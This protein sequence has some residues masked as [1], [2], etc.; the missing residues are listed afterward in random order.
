MSVSK[1]VTKD[2]FRIVGNIE[3]SGDI[4]PIQSGI[5]DLG[6]PDQRFKDIY[7]ADHLDGF[8]PRIHFG[9]FDF[10]ATNVI[11]AR[12]AAALA[13]TA[14]QPGTVDFSTD[15]WNLPTT[16]A[17]YGI[18][19]AVIPGDFV[20][21]AS[22]SLEGSATI[23]TSTSNL[24]VSGTGDAIFESDVF[25]ES[26][27]TLTGL[28]VT[29]N[30]NL[31]GDLIHD[32]NLIPATNN[33]SDLGTT[34][35]RY[36]AA[37]VN[38][39]LYIGAETFKDTDVGTIRD[40]QNGAYATAAQGALADSALQPHDDI[41]VNHI[42]L[43]G[44][45]RG[46]STTYI[47]P[48]GFGD[49]TGKVIIL[50]DLQV[51]GV[52]TTVNST[53]VAVSGKVINLAQGSA[54]AFAA[55][56]SG[57]NV[58]GSGATFK[59]MAGTDCWTTNKRVGIN[60][61]GSTDVTLSV[62][63]SYTG[64]TN[65]DIFHAVDLLDNTRV[66]I[67]DTYDLILS[68]TVNDLTILRSDGRVGI[69]T[70]NPTAALHV[71]TTDAIMLP[72]GTTVQRPLTPTQSQRGYIRYNT[73]TNKLEAF[74]KNDVWYNLESVMDSDKDTYITPELTDGNDDDS[75]HFF[76]RGTEQMSL[77]PAGRLGIGTTTPGGKLHLQTSTVTETNPTFIIESPNPSI[78]FIDNTNVGDMNIQWQSSEGDEPGLRFFRTDPTDPDMVIG[79]EG[80]VGINLTE[81]T[82]PL[83]VV[84][85]NTGLLVD[86]QNPA[87][88]HG[89]RV[90]SGNNEFNDGSEVVLDVRSGTTN[91][92]ILNAHAGSHVGIGTASP[93]RT[94]H[95]QSGEDNVTARFTSTDTAVQIELEDLT[96]R[97]WI[98]ARNDFRFGNNIEELMRIDSTGDVG[99]G[100]QDPLYPLHI[101][102]TDTDRARNNVVSIERAFTPVGAGV[103]Q[104]RFEKNV[105][106][107]SRWCN[108]PVNSTENGY[109]IAL[110]ASCYIADTDFK[111]Y[112]E[113]NYGIWARAGAYTNSND[114]TNQNPTGTINKSYA[115]YVDCL[116]SDNVTINNSYG[117]YQSA[118]Y[119]DSADD[120]KNFFASRV[121]IG[122]EDPA[123]KLQV[124]GPGTIA[125]TDLSK[126]YILAGT[127]T[128][129]IGIDPNEIVC[130]GSSLNIGTA[131]GNTNDVHLR[132]N[133]TNN[134]LTVDGA[135]GRVGINTSSPEE[136]LTVD[137][138]I[139]F[140]ATGNYNQFTMKTTAKFGIYEGVL[141]IRN[142]TIPGTG[143]SEH[144]THFATHSSTT[145]ST[146]HDV[147]IDGRVGIGHVAPGA[148]L[149]VR[150]NQNNSTE[151]DWRN[152]D[153]IKV[154]NESTA[155]GSLMSLQL[156]SP[157]SSI[158]LVG[159]RVSEDS[160]NFHIIS[161]S[162]DGDPVSIMKMT[163][164]GLVGIRKSPSYALDVYGVEET[165]I[166]VDTST[167]DN[168]ALVRFAHQGTNHFVIGHEGDTDKFT[169][170]DNIA[171]KHRLTIDSDGRVGINEYNPETM[172][173]IHANTSSQNPTKFITLTNYSPDLEFNSSLISFQFVDDNSNDDPQVQIGAI[174]GANANANGFIPEGAGAFIV[175]TNNPYTANPD[176]E[177][178]TA[179]NDATDLQERF[180]V[181][182]RGYVGIG[183]S[184]PD[185]MLEID[186]GTGTNV[187]MTLRMGSGSGG[188]ND[189]FISF[190]NSQGSE[191]FRTRF[192][193]DSANERYVISTDQGGDTL[194]V[195]RS[196]NVEIQGDSA[197]N[198]TSS[199][200][201]LVKH[202]KNTISMFLG[203]N[204]VTSGYGTNDYSG[205]IRFNGR[206]VGW[207]D[208]SYYPTATNDLNSMGHFRFTKNGSTVNST[209][210]ARVG[211][212]SL[213][214]H[215]DVQVE[216]DIQAPTMKG[217][218]WTSS[219]Y[220]L[221]T[222]IKPAD[223]VVME[224]VGWSNPNTNGRSEY[225]DPIHLYVYKG[226][227]WNG[228]A[229]T[230]Y[231]YCV[232][233][234][235][236]ARSQFSS[237]T[238][239][240]G[241]DIDVCWVDANGVETD[242]CPNNSTTH[243]LKFKQVD[244]Y[245]LPSP[246]NPS[247]R[248][249][250]TIKE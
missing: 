65:H 75:L 147:L 84:D 172:L 108:I 195:F 91:H 139:R 241:N 80:Y 208:V 220:V 144:A 101:V 201:L 148:K 185:N 59:Y 45:L 177:G 25:V 89:L 39:T 49:N 22:T 133:G 217:K 46:P 207:G 5:H 106:I 239:K 43:S 122:S 74:G 93:V 142:A 237:G 229:P 51:D 163:N 247:W 228:S 15:I 14:L 203:S 72:R 98:E 58:N 236:P 212:G 114:L 88:N 120:S 102:H 104:T 113:Q 40:V 178:T 3:F 121:G 165:A 134:A 34:S 135:T 143:T 192:D 56:G 167:A 149:D 232:Q 30:I 9:D 111:G 11:E 173:H 99:I 103:T 19:D 211:V 188:Y 200:P 23:S 214:S 13:N 115:V 209:P 226:T 100:T 70:M 87:G 44:H 18:T 66:R 248:I 210:S 245:V 105:N 174:V 164:D 219:D 92:P 119:T 231:V 12:D 166:R 2:N 28:T 222:G 126:A 112:L 233:I 33:I 41:V 95:V 186:A 154:V 17:G 152:V 159:E 246:S 235:P 137:G 1:N 37:Y 161:E 78:Q 8:S 198:A 47:D 227:G 60:Y 141:S 169:L 67:S 243:T 140:G 197:N 190:Q 71:N 86:F 136:Q 216:G 68:D 189:S 176:S 62:K 204:E 69:N 48:E 132:Y 27:T 168:D 218:L 129:G 16:I 187:G 179:T 155:T 76:T 63:Q 244:P 206:D 124:I 6:S 205:T 118:N 130:K 224:V 181:D 79:L 21:Q 64:V 150:F 7:L 32:L 29:D 146:R 157:G 199:S 156:V 249:R 109:R 193:N 97:S 10:S 180:R 26:N 128:T 24:I 94:L 202:P 127:T 162:L 82:S 175:K 31:S 123:A 53:S 221:N 73:Q 184:T 238:T 83:H 158:G 85:A 117:I 52:T 250:T 170:H 38:D 153:G 36:K 107:D 183:T 50:G 90:R 213:Y 145:G 96:G 131:A 57:I 110:D 234:S 61:G 35:N 182:Y 4:K 171:N 42:A 242:S 160:M 54:D 116:Q 225:K 20:A 138:D 151:T 125:A 230:D 194:T 55:N 223:F 240:Q 215:G 196:G 77:V 191:L 81:P